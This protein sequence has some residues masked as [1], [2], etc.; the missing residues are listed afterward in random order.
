MILFLEDCAFPPFRQK[1]GERMGHGAGCGSPNSTTVE[2]VQIRTVRNL[3]SIKCGFSF[4]KM[5]FQQD[6]FPGR[7]K[8]IPRERPNLLALSLLRRGRIS[9]F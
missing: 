8:K 2:L 1:K 9:A 7:L 3:A 4:A 6:T 5:Y